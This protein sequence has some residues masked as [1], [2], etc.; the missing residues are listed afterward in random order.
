MTHAPGTPPAVPPSQLVPFPRCPRCAKGAGLYLAGTLDFRADFECKTRG[1]PQH[2]W[3]MR[4]HAGAVLPQ[5]A[6]VVGETLAPQLMFDYLLPDSLGLPM[7]WQ[8][9]L[10]GNQAYHR[11]EDR[12]AGRVPESVPHLKR[13]A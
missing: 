4:L 3:A 2:W 8:L 11:S 7:Y 10:T 6:A 9:S 12:K 5:L 1:C 13:P